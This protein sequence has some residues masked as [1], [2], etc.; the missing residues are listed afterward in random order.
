[1]ISHINIHVLCIV[2]EGQ[3]EASRTFDEKVNAVDVILFLE[4]ILFLI[5]RYW[6]HQGTQPRY[7]ALGLV[8]GKCDSLI[9]CLVNEHRHLN[10][11]S[12]RQ[13]INE[14]LYL[15]IVL[16]LAVEFYLLFDFLK[17]FV[18]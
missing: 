18:G 8:F 10:T 13:F 6:L 11:K 3:H 2:I 16:V 1:M 9:P 14:V 7:E 12:L 4:Y 5:V 17:H 15:Q